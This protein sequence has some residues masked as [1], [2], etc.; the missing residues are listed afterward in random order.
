MCDDPTN[1]PISTSGNREISTLYLPFRS[2]G[3]QSIKF[4][5]WDNLSNMN[6][7]VFEQ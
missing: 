3:R 4:R 7:G 6:S 1:Q 2:L 5:Y